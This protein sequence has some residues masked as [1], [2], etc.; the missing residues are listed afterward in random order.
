MPGIALTQT[1]R[2]D[3]LDGVNDTSLVAGLLIERQALAIM[4]LRQCVVLSAE[5]DGAQVIERL[6]HRPE[7][8]DLAEDRQRMM[9]ASLS[10]GKIAAGAQYLA[11]IAQTQPHAALIVHRHEDGVAFL[12]Q[13]ERARVV[14]VPAR[15]VAQVEQPDGHPACVAKLAFERQTL[16]EVGGGTII[17]GHLDG[18]DSQIVERDS[19][20]LD[21]IQRPLQRQTI[22]VEALSLT[23]VAAIARHHRQQVERP[24]APDARALDSLWEK[25]Q[26]GLPTRHRLLISAL[27]RCQCSLAIERLRTHSDRSLVSRSRQIIQREKV[28]E[29]GASLGERARDDP[30]APERARKAQPQRLLSTRLRPAQRRTQIIVLAG[31]PVTRRILPGASQLWLGVFRQSKEIGGVSLAHA[32]SRSA[33]L[34][35]LG[36]KLANGFEQ[37]KTRLDFCKSHSSRGGVLC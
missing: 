26:H 10:A 17:G 3:S 25:R 4:R 21:I 14:A 23:H 22:E 32:L 35:P 9:R 13:T 33:D 15:H 2:R 27:L 37:V 5:R 36:A 18:D 12:E 16:L 20:A 28:I 6:C 1:D 30:I 29:P 11:L 34:Q 31:E 7:I 8:V 24:H 19:D